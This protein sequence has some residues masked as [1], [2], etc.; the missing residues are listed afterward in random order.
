MSFSHPLAV[1][2]IAITVWWVSTGLVL[3]MV[4]RPEPKEWRILSLMPV[5]TVVGAGG[6]LLMLFGAREQTPLGSYAGFF[7]ALLVWAWHEAAFLTGRLTGPR[8]GDCPPGLSGSARFKAAWQ[9]VSDHEI[10]ILIT[11][12]VLWFTLSGNPNRFGLAAFGLLWG[13]RIS[14]KL[15]IFLGAPHAVSELMPKGIAHLKSY[16]RTDRLTPIFPLLLA[17]AAGLF[18]ILVIGANRATQEHSVVGHTLLATFMALAIIEHLILVLPVSDTALWRWAMARPREQIAAGHP[19]DGGSH[20]QGAR[21]AVTPVA[22]WSTLGKDQIG[23]RK[24]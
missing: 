1:V 19:L 21:P 5:M 14:A 10:A 11:A 6:F 3:A 16:F 18:A 24:D 2:A 13:M 7:G 8:G 4:N 22:S 20:L 17:I 9:A 23:K 15:L 12:V